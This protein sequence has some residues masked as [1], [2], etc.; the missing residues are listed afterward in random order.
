VTTAA[1]IAA[2]YPVTIAEAAA[3]VK[4]AAELKTDPAWLA[5][6]IQGESR[7]NPAARNPSTGATGLIQF[8]PSTARRL[9]TTTAA[10]G[11]MSRL[12][13]LPLVFAFL[14][15]YIGRMNSQRDVYLA[16]FY[17]RFIGKPE[18]TAFPAKVPAQNPG[19][20]R[21]RDLVAKMNRNAKLPVDSVASAKAAPA[22]LPPPIAAP[23]AAPAAPAT[24]IIPEPPAQLAPGEDKGGPDWARISRIYNLTALSALGATLIVVLI[25][26]ARS[27]RR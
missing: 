20:Y 13:Q 25:A 5:N 23:I 12:Q 6:A 2:A 22:S 7:W 3:L 26:R 1:Q 21:I 16:I 18:A 27:L 15:P 17:P 4:V 14:K 10:I 19:I 9:G 11:R 24:A 8:M